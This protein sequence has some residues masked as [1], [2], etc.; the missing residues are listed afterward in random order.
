[1]FGIAFRRRPRVLML[2]AAAML[3]IGGMMVPFAASA[4]EH[5]TV[6]TY[7]FVVGFVNEPAVQGQMNGIDLTITQDG[8]PVTGADQ[9]LKAQLVFGSSSKDVDLTAVYKQDGKYTAPFIPT[10][11]GDYSF[12]FTGTIAGTTINEKFTSS[13]T[14]FDAVAPATDYEFPPASN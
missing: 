3:A 12:V 4:H 14:T 1:M 8:K 5:R 11:P 2:A 9:T 13:P 6:G 7:E 10:Q